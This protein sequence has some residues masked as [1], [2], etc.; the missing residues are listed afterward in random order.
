MYVS[1]TPH[2]PFI[3]PHPVGQ[4]RA[5][6]VP[7]SNPPSGNIA[8]PVNTSNISQIKNGALGVLSLNAATTLDGSG[9]V[10]GG[11]VRAENQMRANQYCDANGE[12]CITTASIGPS[13][14]R[15]SC[16]NRSS[17]LSSSGSASVSCIT[18]EVATG[19]GC[20]SSCSGVGTGD[21][22]DHSIDSS[23]PTA[24]GWSCR[25]SNRA[26]ATVRCCVLN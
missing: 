12:N 23:L 7:P 8:A 21:C 1:Q 15:L 4:L 26:I 16:V 25:V 20:V 19:G 10:V 14:T 24:N 9:N 6:T 22:T 2:H 17:S 18:P 3:R 13:M 5:W 11:I